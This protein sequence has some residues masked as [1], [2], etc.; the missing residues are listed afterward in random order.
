MDNYIKNQL[1][2]N[3]IKAL[4][5]EADPIA[6]KVMSNAFKKH[7]F[8]VDISSTGREAVNLFKHHDYDFVLLDFDLPD[9]FGNEVV[10]LIRK[11]EYK[12]LYPRC[13]IAIC[14]TAIDSIQKE[15]CFAAGVNWFF[16]SLYLVK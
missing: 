5:V 11:Y 9:M 6:Q 3:S 16:R 15:E 7:G 12:Y 1:D 14:T 10:R 13:P 8:E 2:N 4:I